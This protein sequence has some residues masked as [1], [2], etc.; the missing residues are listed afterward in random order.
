VGYN[1]DGQ[2]NVGNWTSISQV[3]AGSSHTVGLRSDGTVV[4]VGYNG[5]DRCSVGD[6]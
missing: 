4:A 5:D 2:C 1:G 3:A 6:W